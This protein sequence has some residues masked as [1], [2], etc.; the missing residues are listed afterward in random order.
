MRSKLEG[1]E[2][3][4]EELSQSLAEPDITSDMERYRATTRSYAELEPL[5]AKFG[6]YRKVEEDLDGARELLTGA[7]D[8][9]MKQMASEEVASLEAR[10]DALSDEL[11][12][13][14]LPSDPND[15]KN[16]V[17]EI[18]AGT[19]GDEATLFAAELM[20]MYVRFAEGQKWKVRFT[21]LSTSS[22]DGVKEA[23][24]IIEGDRV[25]S[26]LK[27]E[28]G[29][30]RVQRVPATESQGR[31]H[32]SA[33]TVAVMPEAEDVEVEIDDNELRVDTFCS[34]GPGGQSVNTT[35]SAVRLTHLPTNLVVQCQD[36]KSWH[37]NKARAM[38]VLRSRLYDKMLREQQEAIAAER[39]GMVGT[40][41]RA[42]KI[43][44]YNFPQGRVT[45]HRIGFSVHNL[46][47]VMTGEI[48]PLLEALATH[49]Q[50]ERLKQEVEA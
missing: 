12:V 3:R 24:L 8:E 29:V 48:S 27:F 9:E 49:E 31:V 43:R 35:Q 46:P 13:L 44:T 22:V 18:R 20:R 36:E 42:E 19:G 10:L 30:H 21:D 6:E 7:D 5:V 16:I 32:T 4:A 34:S 40:G 14:L 41:D 1:I 28:S 2:Q 33:V 23:I 38:K 26:R 11:R 39:R 47:A 37:K 15:A 17:L 45:D 25:Y 50:A